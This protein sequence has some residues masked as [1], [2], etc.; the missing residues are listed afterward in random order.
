MAE[1]LNYEQS[2]R[3]LQQSGWLKDGEIPKLPEQP[4]QYDDEILGVEFFRTIVE[5]GRFENLTLPRTYFGRSEIRNSSFAGSD[6]TE[7]VANWNDF[8]NVNFAEADLTKFDFR[9]CS[10]QKINFGGS[11]LKDADLRCCGFENCNFQ[12][13]VMTGAKMTKETGATISLAPSQREGIDW[14]DDDGPEPGGG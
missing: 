11:I 4:P 1:R 14:R 10:L 9:G 13:A 8:I 3:F 6:L 2:C 12:D 5:D 7:S